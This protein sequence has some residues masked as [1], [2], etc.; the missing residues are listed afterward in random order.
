MKHKLRFL[1]VF[2]CFSMFIAKAQDR[3][4][5]GTVSSS[6]DESAVPGVN[7]VVKGTAIGTISDIDGKYSIMV[8]SDESILVFSYIGLGTQEIV[9]GVRSLIDVKMIVDMTELTEI[10]ITAVGIEREKLIKIILK[11]QELAVATTTDKT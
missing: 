1:T 4:V 3:T 2:L 11:N 8:P 9:V 10:V 7:V 6:E 5:S